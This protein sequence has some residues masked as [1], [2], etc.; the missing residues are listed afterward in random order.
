MSKRPSRSDLLGAID[1]LQGLIGM[2]MGANGD[3]NPN[4]KA[5]VDDLLHRAHD[6]CVEARSGDP[7]TAGS[8]STF[9][10]RDTRSTAI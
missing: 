8:R 7:P 3:R 9:A 10:G 4:R 2:A 1:S 5:K 6:L